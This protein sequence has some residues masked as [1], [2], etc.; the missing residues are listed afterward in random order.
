MAEVDGQLRKVG[1][2]IGPG[3]HP[4]EEA[5]DGEGVPQ[6][7]KARTARADRSPEPEVSGQGDKGASGDVI[8]QEGAP[9]RDE[10]EIVGLATARR[11]GCAA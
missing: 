6:R 1:V 2:H 7:V 11:K 8:V 9:R 10:E 4:G 3:S 5:S